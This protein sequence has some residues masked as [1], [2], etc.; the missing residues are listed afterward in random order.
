[1]LGAVPCPGRATGADEGGV[2]V[3]AAP[4]AGTPDAAPEIGA[5]GRETPPGD[6]VSGRGARP[7]TEAPGGGLALLAPVRE[8][9]RGS[10]ATGG[11]PAITGADVASDAGTST[12]SFAIGLRPTKAGAA[13][14]ESAPGTAMFT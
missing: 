8:V 10:S 7:C 13:T 4:T 1:V 3:G 2:P 5:V 6:V 9:G 14:A 11:A 12:R